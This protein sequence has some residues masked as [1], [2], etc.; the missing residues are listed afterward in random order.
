MGKVRTMQQNCPMMP[1][2]D[3]L[4]RAEHGDPWAVLLVGILQAAPSNNEMKLTRS[5]LACS[6]VDSSDEAQPVLLGM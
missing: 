6:E 2:V 5:G 3:E 1:T 4:R